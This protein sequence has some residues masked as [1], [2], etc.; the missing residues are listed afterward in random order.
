MARLLESP[1]KRQ[2]RRQHYFPP[3]ADWESIGVWEGAG[4]S[5]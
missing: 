1:A 2:F 3:L 4:G 5:L